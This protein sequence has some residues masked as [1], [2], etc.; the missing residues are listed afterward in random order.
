MSPGSERLPEDRSCRRAM[1]AVISVAGAAW[2]AA[3][4]G[5]ATDPATP[6]ASSS[7]AAAATGDASGLVTAVDGGMATI[8]AS[9]GEAA[10]EA[11]I[12]VVPP[13]APL[14]LLLDSLMVA[15][16]AEHGIG[17]AAMG[18]GEGRR[19]RL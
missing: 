12:R 7:H 14:D 13:G 11:V 5:G 15:F 16:A 3:C 6:P 2:I 17:A 4:G 18:R 19:H 8:T 9:A 1:N 10:G